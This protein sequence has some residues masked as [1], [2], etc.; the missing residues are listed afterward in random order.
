MQGLKIKIKLNSVFLVIAALLLVSMMA[1]AAHCVN[2]T[3]TT[4]IIRWGQIEIKTPYNKMLYYQNRFAAAVGEACGYG[5]KPYAIESAKD[6]LNQ[7]EGELDCNNFKEIKGIFTPIGRYLVYSVG[8]WWK[9]FGVSWK[10]ASNYFLTIYGLTLIFLFCIYRFVSNNLLAAIATLITGNVYLHQLLIGPR[11]FLTAFFFCGVVLLSLIIICRKCSRKKLFLIAFFGGFFCGIGI[12][13]KSDVTALIVLFIFSICFSNIISDSIR[14]RLRC[15][16]CAIMVFLATV[17]CAVLPLVNANT[18]YAVIIEGLSLSFTNDLGL[19]T[20]HLYSLIPFYNDYYTLDIV[21]KYATTLLHKATIKDMHGNKLY[22]LYSKKYYFQYLSVFTA[23][24][25]VRLISS[26]RLL[27]SGT[28]SYFGSYQGSL[29]CIFISLIGFFF[30]LARNI[31]VGLVAFLVTIGACSYCVLQFHIRH[32]FYLS[33][34]F[35]LFY[36]LVLISLANKFCGCFFSSKKKTG[37]CFLDFFPF[38]KWAVAICLLATITCFFT[39]SSLRAYQNGKVKLMIK[40]V[41]AS[42][43]TKKH[44]SVQKSDF[45]W[46][47]HFKQKDNKKNAYY[48]LT[49]RPG[50]KK[51]AYNQ[52]ASIYSKPNDSKVKTVKWQLWK[53]VFAYPMVDYY[54]DFSVLLSTPSNGK[55]IK[56]LVPI[57]KTHS[58]HTAWRGFLIPQN[59]LKN[60]VSIESIDDL[61]QFPIQP[62]MVIPSDWEKKNYYQSFRSVLN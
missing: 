53:R 55:E 19:T 37:R 54:G 62:F 1:Y 9:I 16:F 26:S 47:I 10:S 21:N 3:A 6:F 27:L 17:Y 14:E 44:Y 2:S 33:S 41:L 57:N 31:R 61:S 11:D 42:K 51:T 34:F 13:F 50:E 48:V 24:F 49:F 58:S 35:V 32:N 36:S 29:Y 46:L 25:F 59:E 28:I 45:G 12:G 52:L 56:F 30:L 40:A 60:L 4:R 18:T 43:K 8:L 5:F 22:Y 38:L 20:H 15:I 7:K 39:L 23:D